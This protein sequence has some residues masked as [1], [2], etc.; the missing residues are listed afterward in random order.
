MCVTLKSFA[1]RAVNGKDVFGEAARGVRSL[2]NI[3]HP[4]HIYYLALRKE[5]GVTP[6][7]VANDAKSTPYSRLTTSPAATKRTRR[8]SPRSCGPM[9][10]MGSPR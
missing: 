9:G 10:S 3:M 7:P 1:F 2:A 5:L 8:S 6:L 4:G